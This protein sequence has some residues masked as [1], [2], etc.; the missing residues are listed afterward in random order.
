VAVSFFEQA[1]QTTGGRPEVVITDNAAFYPLA[2]ERVRIPTVAY[3]Y[4]DPY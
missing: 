3:H 2:L 4:I 1:L